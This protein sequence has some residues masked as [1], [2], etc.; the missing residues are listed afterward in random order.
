MELN[1]G[2]KKKLKIIQLSL[3]LLGLILIFLHTQTKTQIIKY[4]ITLKLLKK[5]TRLM[6][7]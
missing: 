6:K 1:D 7:K 5:K 4:L 2:K 3:L